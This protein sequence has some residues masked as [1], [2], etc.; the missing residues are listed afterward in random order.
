ML[1]DSDRSRMTAA[2]QRGWMLEPEAKRLLASIGLDVPRH[3]WVKRKEDIASAA[4]QIG[5]PLVAKV[6]SPLLMHKTEQNGVAVGIADE[7]E[8]MQR[9]DHFSAIDGFDGMLI[10]EMLSGVELIVGYQKDH[11]FGPVILM[12]IGGTGV[13][14]YQDI[15]IKMAP[16]KQRDAESMLDTL[17]ARKLL[18]GFRGSK[19]VDID[20]LF[21]LLLTFSDFVLDI[22]EM[23]AS[24]DLNP[25]ICSQKRC[26]IADALIVFEEQD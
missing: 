4:R 23:A 5:Y 10:E 2:L 22:Q 25:V 21:E 3:R 9:Y 14:I 6:V 17:K 13:E 11:Q 1:S 20:K 16:L 19:P 26:T 8:L 7:R 18:T 15:S 12:G 24:I